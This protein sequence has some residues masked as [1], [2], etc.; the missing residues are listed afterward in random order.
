M[1]SA[2][3][4]S[5]TRAFTVI[6]CFDVAAEAIDDLTVSALAAEFA[7]DADGVEDFANDIVLKGP[8]QRRSA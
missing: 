3:L 5:V 7:L 1:I 6:H 2:R 4:D 8:A